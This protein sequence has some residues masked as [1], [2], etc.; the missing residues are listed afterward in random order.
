MKN[1]MTHL[2]RLA[3]ALPALLLGLAFAAPVAQAQTNT[4]LVCNTDGGTSF[5]NSQNVGNGTPGKDKR[6]VAQKFT[7]GS[8]V[9]GYILNK[10]KA[11]GGCAGQC[12]PR[13]RIHSDSAGSPGSHI[14]TNSRSFGS[15]AINSALA[16]DYELD[17]NTNYWAVF[18]DVR[19][20][21]GVVQSGVYNLIVTNASS[22]DC[23]TS[24]DDW[25]WSI[26]NDL[27][28]RANSSAAWQTKDKILLIEMI[29]Y[30]NNVAAVGQ[31]SISGTARTGQTLTADKAGITD[32]NGIPSDLNY[33]W[34]RVDGSNETSITGA[35]ARTYSPVRA[36]IG[37]KVK[38]RI[39]FTDKSG[40][41]E[42]TTSD[43]YPDSDSI[44]QSP[45]TASDATISLLEDAIHTFSIADFNYMDV[46]GDV[47]SS[48]QITDLP[49]LGALTLNGSA[50]AVNQSISK[51]NLDAGKLEYTP[52]ENAYGD[53]YDDLAFKVNDGNE[54]SSATY[55]LTFDVTEVND[56]AT[57]EVL[58]NA[59]DSYVG[60]TFQVQLQYMEDPD[61]LTKVSYNYQW[62]WIIVDVHQTV[63]REED[64]PHATNVSYT[65]TNK[66]IG[67]KYKVRVTFEDDLGHSEVLESPVF[68]RNDGEV[69]ISKP[70]Y[71]SLSYWDFVERQNGTVH[72]RFDLSS[73][74]QFYMHKRDMRKH[75]F[76]V[77]NGVVKR[78]YRLNPVDWQFIPGHYQP[79]PVTRYWRIEVKPIDPAQDVVIE[80]ESNR[81]C[82]ERGAICSIG[83][84]RYTEGTSYTYTPSVDPLTVAIQD[85]TAVEDGLMLFDVEISRETKNIVKVWTRTTQEGT[86][87][88]GEDF[89]AEEHLTLF[90]HSREGSQGL[91]K[92]IGVRIH[93]DSYEDD[94]ETVVVEIA[95]AELIK[96]GKIRYQLPITDNK[97]TGTITDSAQNTLPTISV[98]PTTASVTEGDTVDLTISVTPAPDKIVRV[99]YVLL[100][101][102]AIARQDFEVPVQR[103]LCFLPTGYTSGETCKVDTTQTI[104][105]TTID[106]AHDDSGEK[107]TLRLENASNAVIDG[108]VV[109]ITITNDDPLQKAWLS[110]F[111]RTI[112]SQVVD[113]VTDRLSNVPTESHVTVAGQTIALDSAPTNDMRDS[114]MNSPQEITGRELLLGSSFHVV[115]DGEDHSIGAWGHVVVGGFDTQQ[116]SDGGT[117]SIDGT[118][119]TGILGFD[120]E[121]EKLLAGVAV[122]IS[123]GEGDFHSPN[124][125]KGTGV[126][127]STLASI[128][129][130]ARYQ[131]NDRL[132]YWGLLGYGAGDMTV[133]QG[134]QEIIHTDI[135]MQLGAGGA[136]ADLVNHDGTKLSLGGDAFLVQMVSAEA[137]NSV[138]T[139]AQ[140]SRL[141]TTLEGSHSVKLRSHETLISGLEVG[142]RH[143]AGDAETG[144]GLEFGGSL[145]YANEITGWSLDIAFQKLLIHEDT[146]YDEWGISGTVGLAAGDHGRGASLSISTAYGSS[147]EGNRLWNAQEVVELADNSFEP[148][149]QISAELGYGMW[150]G[151]G[152]L[153][154]YVELSKED[155]QVGLRWRR[156][157]FNW[158]AVTAKDAIQIRLGITF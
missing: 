17:P 63:L 124:I 30:A 8:H 19:S 107:F 32:A 132:H 56:P 62:V 28:W 117:V 86:A 115:T 109:T 122:A 36:D 54:Y 114:E 128:N 144:F 136:Q 69:V 7:T 27:R 4:A 98:S 35:S 110:R 126:I 140:A 58:F 42:S 93:S 50:V 57:G 130:Y 60:S 101:G 90:T 108:N 118:V 134:D 123:D 145:Q 29:G 153:T 1:T 129:P 151:T 99:D 111:G 148:E 142:L 104:T 139:K 116:P 77:T 49:D 89:R 23:A 95:R 149:H 14:G 152:M 158:E 15:R 127:E 31:P 103:T 55:I 40:W 72:Y 78:A 9:N 91:T 76:N 43:A 88:E 16:G 112:A 71:I 61:G 133:T 2:I 125:V 119:T 83:G 121:W 20:A 53:N 155:Q 6:I 22:E 146:K 157:N 3:V 39:D 11:E 13:I 96:N 10:L 67:K 113:A 24:S 97:A 94:G 45:P 59:G 85:T 70:F 65:L 37:K 79:K 106:D 26:A 120:A 154:P 47:L 75:A 84:E 21:S 141:R 137:P 52:V 105:I 33:Q 80:L 64:I 131:A 46:D 81:T 44:R 74:F 12:R 143:D 92:Q 66:D 102:T 68:P 48:I 150:A 147:G 138:E 5:G 100:S 34:I 73:N 38:V 25:G 82:D 51:T 18:E 87:T 41:D 135:S 156:D